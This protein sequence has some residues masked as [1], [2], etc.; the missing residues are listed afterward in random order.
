VDKPVSDHYNIALTYAS[1]SSFTGCSPRATSTIAMRTIACIACIDIHTPN[2]TIIHAVGAILVIAGH[3][4][5][6]ARCVHVWSH[7]HR[8]IAARHPT[9]P[10]CP[11]QI[12]RQQPRQYLLIHDIVRPAIGVE[13]G[14]IELLVRQIQPGRPFVVEVGER[15][16]LQRGLV[17]TLGVQPAVA[18]LDE[19][20][21]G[22]ADRRDARIVGGLAPG[23]R[24]RVRRGS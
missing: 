13:D 16:L 21:G 8:P 7:I 24:R 9:L 2:T 17:C 22:G 20:A 19:I 11:L 3:A 15:A 6:A 5:N 10:R 1:M 12:Q 14:A 18:L 23:D 4:T